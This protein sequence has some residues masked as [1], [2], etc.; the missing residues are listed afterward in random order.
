M[1]CSSAARA[2]VASR[3]KMLSVTSISSRWA[4][5]P[6]AASAPT[7]LAREAG[8]EQL[9]ARNVDRDLDVA[10]ASCI[11]SRQASRSTH[12]PIGTISRV[13]SASGMNLAGL[14]KPCSSLFQ[15]ISASK[16]TMCFAARIDH[17]LIVQHELVALERAAQREFEL[18]AFLG[19]GVQRRLELAM[20]RPP[21]SSLER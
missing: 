17:R 6:L 2:V 5:S 3:T 7:T 18:A 11:A 10:R 12:S 19:M 9:L 16:L 15:R 1:T 14:T 8:I 21:P 13:S 20:V 4:G